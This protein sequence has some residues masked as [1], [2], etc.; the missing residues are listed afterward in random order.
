MTRPAAPTRTTRRAECACGAVLWR[1]VLDRQA[2]RDAADVWAC[3]RCG[4]VRAVHLFWDSST[5]P[6]SATVAGWADEDLAPHVAEWAGAWPRLVEGHAAVYLPSWVRCA[7]EAE[8]VALEEHARQAQAHG[9]PVRR[10]D[11]AG[12]PADPPPRDLPDELGFLRA[13]WWVMRTPDAE[14]ATAVEGDS[15]LIPGEL[16]GY[17]RLLAYEKT[18]RQ[19]WA[20]DLAARLDGPDRAAALREIA[21]GRKETT[22]RSWPV[23][24]SAPPPSLRPLVEA[25]PAG[26]GVAAAL[27]AF[28]RG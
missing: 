12:W 21:H 22:Y 7:S 14:V 27:A 23:V 24:V 25:L 18:V 16:R 26:P 4:H 17:V 20:E 5:D 8:L 28:D 9:S 1:T 15:A 11:A 19:R 3:L 2:D 10:V 6:H 13:A